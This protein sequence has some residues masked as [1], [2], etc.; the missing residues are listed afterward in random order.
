[1]RSYLASISF[2]DAMVGRVLDALEQGPHRDNTI[3]VFTSDHGWYLGEKQRWH[4]GGLWERATRVPLVIV[5]PGV[6]QPDTVCTQPVSLVDLYPTLCDLSG[7]PAPKHLDGE[8][9]L[10]QLAAPATVRTRPAL[11]AMGER[12]GASYSARTDRWRYTRY[13]DGSE[14]LYDHLNDPPEWTN[15]AGKPAQAAR[16]KELAALL[17]TEWTSASRTIDQVKVDS[18]PDGMVSYFFQPGDRLEPDASPDVLERAFDIEVNFVYNPAVDADSSLLSQ[19]GAGLGFALHLVAGVPAITVNYDGLH[20]TLKGT[21]AL[22][23]GPIRLRALLALD[24]SMALSA[25]GL[26]KEVRGYAPF[27]GGFPRRPAEGLSVGSSFGPLT[28]KAFP[29]STPF[30]GV[31]TLVRMTILPGVTEE[32]RAARAVPVE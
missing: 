6:T 12:T 19:G 5:A 2:C 17:P 11:T 20:A 25:T 1:V 9:L 30:D 3:V 13:A 28:V 26:T 32:R 23:A 14:E 8:S 16:K 18:S 22:A 31:M 15:L 27:E 21:E 29:N 7:L 10:P 4:K 24:G